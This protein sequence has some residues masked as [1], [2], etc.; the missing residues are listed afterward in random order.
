M[1]SKEAASKRIRE[2]EEEL[3]GHRKKA[4]ST[5]DSVAAEYTCPLSLELFVDPVRAEDGFDYEKSEIERVVQHQGE[6][7]TS[8]QTGETMGPTLTPSYN[9]KNAVE[10]L[11]TT[12]TISGELA[13]TYK[14][15]KL[16]MET[17][18]K[19]E[20]GDVKSMELLADWYK[21]G[22]NG[23]PVSQELSD[24]WR[25]K[26][27]KADDDEYIT[28]LKA[29]AS[30]GDSAAMYNLGNAYENGLRGLAMD[31]EKA[32]EWYS[33]AADEMD[34][35]GIA[36]KAYFLVN[37]HGGAEADVAYGTS[38]MFYAAGAGSDLASREVGIWYLHGMHGIPANK[39]KARYFLD[40]ATN[41]LCAELHMKPA[42]LD[43]AKQLL[44]QLQ[45]EEEDNDDD[46]E[47]KIGATDGV[48]RSSGTKK[49]K[50]NTRS[51]EPRC[52]SIADMKALMNDLGPA[53]KT[54]REISAAAKDSA[55]QELFFEWFPDFYAQFRYDEKRGRYLPKYRS[56]REERF[57]RLRLR[58]ES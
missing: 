26:A 52:P 7:L 12:G 27:E 11:V 24:G 42:D 58:V 53:S 30:A 25:R 46:E 37:E 28:Q 45:Q 39:A 9:V 40:R 5:S 13:E 15:S 29:S 57:R 22:W 55:I 34:T 35:A 47:R 10:A 23:L 17:R 3:E 36:M 21:V 6:S 19:A 49:S 1:T 18:R 14:N 32:F 31:E 41:G 33:K 2:L 54:A 20:D 8:P 38:Q 16:V 43:E 51:M 50:T 56:L 44:N 48:S 4:K